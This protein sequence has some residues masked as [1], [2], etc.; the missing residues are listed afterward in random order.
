MQ[1]RKPRLLSRE[2]LGDV[3]EAAGWGEL[4]RTDEDLAEAIAIDRVSKIVHARKIVHSAP[5]AWCMRC[6]VTWRSRARV[7]R[8]YCR[9]CRSREMTLMYRSARPLL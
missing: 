6:D 2:D 8:P 1:E 5:T 4:A 3:L 7:H 9:R